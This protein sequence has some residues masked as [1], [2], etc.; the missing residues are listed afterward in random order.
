MQILDSARD[1]VR[2]EYLAALRD[3]RKERSNTFK[4]KKGKG[5]YSRKNKHKEW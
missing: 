2:E 4:P 1:K 3:G 5:S